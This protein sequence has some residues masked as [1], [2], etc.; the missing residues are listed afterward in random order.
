MGCLTCSFAKF[1]DKYLLWLGNMSFKKLTIFLIIV[2][3]IIWIISKKI[4]D[5]MMNRINFQ[6]KHVIITGGSSGLGLSLGVLSAQRGAHVSII[7]RNPEK[8]KKAIETISSHKISD[9]QTISAFSADVSS[10]D[11]ISH[12]V[13]KAVKYSGPPF[14]VIPCAGESLPA[15]FSQQPLDEFHSQMNLNFFGTVNTI[16][17]VLPEM[18]KLAAD[19][20]KK[21]EKPKIILVGSA[22]SLLGF[23]GFSAYCSSKFAIKGLAD[24]LRNEFK[25]LNIE[26]HIFYPSTMETP[27]LIEESKRKPSETTEIEGTAKAFSAEDSAKSL[28][29]GVEKGNFHITQEFLIYFARTSMN[30]LS[31]VNNIFFDT[32]LAPFSLIASYI[33]SVYFDYIVRKGK[34]AKI[35]KESFEKKLK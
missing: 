28:F 26:V 2:T 34:L 22:A 21:K 29:S 23:I 13:N 33:M 27:G 1:V 20:K 5:K 7:A 8:L 14:I 16:K 30:G 31:P 24:C 6:G 10:F 9:S 15:Y 4:I 17:A 18:T 32:L 19:K 25:A 35:T 12:A 11:S 3:I